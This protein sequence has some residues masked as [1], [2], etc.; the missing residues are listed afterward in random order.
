MEKSAEII[1]VMHGPHRA[2]KNVSNESQH[3]IPVGWTDLLQRNTNMHDWHLMTANDSKW[4]AKPNGKTCK[5]KRDRIATEHAKLRYGNET[6]G[7]RKCPFHDRREFSPTRGDRCL[8]FSTCSRQQERVAHLLHSVFY[9]VFTVNWHK[10]KD[11]RSPH[12]HE[13][14]FPLFPITK[15]Y[16]L[17]AFLFLLFPLNFP[18]INLTTSFSFFFIVKSSLSGS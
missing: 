8:L 14:F 2:P 18:S 12:Y 6:C 11:I 9:F 13:L 4:H 16:Q 15:T 5:L 1:V 10:C 17:P 7:N 3:I